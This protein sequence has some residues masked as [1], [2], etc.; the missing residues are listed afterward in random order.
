MSWLDNLDRDFELFK[1][2]LER[3]VRARE[4]RRYK[5]QE[6]RRKRRAKKKNEQRSQ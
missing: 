6:E 3:E 1:R 4:V 2:D 5:R